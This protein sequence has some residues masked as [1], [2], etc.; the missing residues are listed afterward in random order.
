MDDEIAAEI[1]REV[2]EEMER[3]FMEEME[4]AS[5]LYSPLS[6]NSCRSFAAYA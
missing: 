2:I 6:S 5:S 1:E 3:E 4:G